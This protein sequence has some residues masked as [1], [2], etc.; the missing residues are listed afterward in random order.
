MIFVVLIAVIV[1]KIT[2][3]G[4][5]LGTVLMGVIAICSLLTFLRDYPSIFKH[6]KNWIHPPVNSVVIEIYATSSTYTREYFGI[7]WNTFMTETR[8]TL[9]N[10]GNETITDFDSRITFE[11]PHL[12]AGVGK[13]IDMPCC[14]FYPVDQTTTAIAFE[15]TEGESVPIIPIRNTRIVS[16]YRLVCES[17]RPETPYEFVLASVRLNDAQ[18]RPPLFA[19]QE[20]PPFVTIEMTYKINDFLKSPQTQKIAL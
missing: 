20:K 12:I 14:D 13:V 15:T 9:I 6:I 16:T 8:L 5:V 2:F 3:G 1:L 4:G 7:H 19:P 17:L 10:N 11:N 18:N